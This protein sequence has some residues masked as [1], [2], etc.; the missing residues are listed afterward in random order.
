M[1][2][3]IGGA[4]IT[5]QEGTGQRKTERQK[6]LPKKESFTKD[7]H[8]ERER[9]KIMPKILLMTMRTKARDDHLKGD[10]ARDCNI[11]EPKKKFA[12]FI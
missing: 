10:R 9:E 2:Y 7:L 11:Q 4:S 5:S 12:D 1:F 6:N 8:D 3:Y